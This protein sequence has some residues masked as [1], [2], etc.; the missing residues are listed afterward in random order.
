MVKG[1]VGILEPSVTV[2]QWM[3]I[4][5]GLNSLVKGLVNEWIVITLTEYI[6]HDTP[7]IQVQ[8][9]AQVELVYR[10]SFVPFEL[11]YIG[12]PLLVGLVCMELAVQKILSNILGILGSSGTAVAVV[13]HRRTYIPGLA[14]PQYS[15]VVYTDSIVMTKIVVES[16]VALVRAFLVDF[17]DF[18]SQALIFLSS[19]AQLSRIPFVV[20]RTGCMEQFTGCFNR[21]PLF[22]MTFLNRLVKLALSYFREASL[23]ST[24][25]NFFNRSRSISA[26]YSLCLSCS[27]SICACS[28]S[29]RGF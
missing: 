21:E 15:L 27:I 10:D 22:L 8:N 12:Q 9:G 14:N 28:N 24:S 17:F 20:S 3:G 29:V 26:R 16:P 4:R 11:C 23:L 7:V 5:V 2:K 19:A 13:L 1:S 25:F 6:G 18:V